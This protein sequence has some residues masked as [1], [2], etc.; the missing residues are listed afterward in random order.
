MVMDTP[1]RMG[2]V[3]INLY[4]INI[5]HITMDG[6]TMVI[7]IETSGHIMLQDPV[8]IQHADADTWSG[9]F[10]GENLQV[11]SGDEFVHTIKLDLTSTNVVVF[12]GQV[13]PLDDEQKYNTL[14]I[15]GES[16]LTVPFLYDNRIIAEVAA[17]IIIEEGGIQIIHQQ[18]YNPPRPTDYGRYLN[19][20]R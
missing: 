18:I 19:G 1:I 7:N 9:F 2:M 10:T 11:E 4:D 14:Y 8:T 16:E 6:N 3:D 20:K 13:E 12:T 17:K 15:N 5:T